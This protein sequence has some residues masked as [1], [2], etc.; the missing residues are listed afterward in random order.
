MNTKFAFLALA[1]VALLIAGC[2]SSPQN[3]IVG[4]WEAGQAGFKVTTEFTRDGK[5]ALTMFG[6]QV[7]GTYK[8][9]GNDELEQTLNGKTTKCKVKVT[10]K[11]LE[12]TN[13]EGKTVT[14]KKV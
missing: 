7:H 1:C 13:T 4:K 12:L 2:G 10:A 5:V 3:R 9:N 6:Q 8:M 14:Y 11:E